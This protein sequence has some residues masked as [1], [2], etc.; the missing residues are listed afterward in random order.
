MKN[1]FLGIISIL[2]SG[3]VC[4]LYFNNKLGYFLIPRMQIYLIIAGIFLFVVGLF[5]LFSHDE[6]IFG[7]SELLLVIPFIFILF[8]GDGK[9][10]L[11]IANNRSSSLQNKVEK[12]EEKEKV[13]EVVIPKEEKKEEVIDS[14]KEII[15]KIDIDVVDESYAGLSDQITYSRNVN[16][17]IGKTIRVRGFAL[18][19]TDFIPN[20]MFG[21]GKYLISCC[22]ADASFYGFFVEGDLSSIKEEAWYELEGILDVG[23]DTYGQDVVV[24]KL[25]NIKEISSKNEEYYIYPCYSYGDGSCKEVT[26]Y[27]LN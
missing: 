22:A 16:K 19:K 6:D 14:K 21:I 1:K 17:L 23:K 27:N 5:L 8:M 9:L 13:K 4:Y 18:K 24:I 7:F 2:L 11:N 12:I 25:I 20:G 3:V 15:T 10:T 26:K